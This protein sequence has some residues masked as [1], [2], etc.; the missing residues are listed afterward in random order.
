[1]YPP[2]TRTLDIL[3]LLAESPD[4]L[5]LSAIGAKLKLPKSA[6]HR[7]LTGLA[8]RGFVRRQ[9]DSSQYALTLKLASLGFRHLASTRIDEI[10]QPVLDRLAADCGELARL[11][12]VDG[13]RMTWVAKAQGTLEG[14]RYDAD[15]GR[16][17]VL[18]ATA[19]G[20]V[21]LASLPEK[22]ALTIVLR[23][24][25]AAV[26]PLG[27]RAVRTAAAL[28]RELQST[29]RRGYGEAVDEGE[30]GV[31]ALAAA[32]QAGKRGDECVVGTVSLAGPTMRLDAARRAVLVPLL[33][34]AAR[35][36]TETWP[37]RVQQQRAAAPALRRPQQRDNPPMSAKEA[38]H[39]E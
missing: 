14:L 7:L 32:I 5:A 31:A 11:A 16:D 3:E 18:H 28:R 13:E 34:G 23:A 25:F 19:V 37:V 9:G 22:D 21:W 39:A 26:R 33:Q 27:P 36:L 1:V 10:A 17:V 24:G 8:E 2:A 29:R 38:M 12:V 6:A 4:G 35:E 30:H 20:K 15:A